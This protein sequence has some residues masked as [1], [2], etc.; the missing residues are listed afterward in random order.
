[1]SAVAV[2]PTTDTAPPP[3]PRWQDT[4]VWVLVAIVTLAAASAVVSWRADDELYQPDILLA[5]FADLPDDPERA[6]ALAEWIA[7]AAIDALRIEEQLAAALP[8][9]LG[10]FA[11]SL[12]ETLEGVAAD[13]SS[14]LVQTELFADIWNDALVATHEQFALAAQGSDEGL[15]QLDNGAIA[16]DLDEAILATYRL[17]ADAVPDIPE[18]SLFS[19]V[20]GVDTEAVKDSIG[21]FLEW[22]VPDDL[23]GFALIESEE[24]AG[25]QRWDNQLGIIL[26]V[27]SITTIAAAGVAIWL[28]AERR[29]VLAAAAVALVAGV[30]IGIVTVSAVE[31]A[32]VTALRELPWEGG[33]PSINTVLDVWTTLSIIV[34]LFVAGLAITPLVARRGPPPGRHVPSELRR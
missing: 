33:G 16:L 2:T 9:G 22:A 28:A 15:L 18:D 8:F 5:A 17:I 4:L 13:V 32:I 14:R 1:M 11:G 12:T 27:S 21:R 23:T 3:R 34:V 30:I 6:Q 20:T 19:R 25:I 24:L 26:W 10:V 31:N 7:E 29:I